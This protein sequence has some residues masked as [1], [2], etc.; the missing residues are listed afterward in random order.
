MHDTLLS[1]IDGS[2]YWWYFFYCVSNGALVT[3][4]VIVVGLPLLT[5][6]GVF[7]PKWGGAITAVFGALLAYLGLSGVS[8]SFIT[9]RNDL[10]IAKYRY[11]SDKD[12]TAKD[13]ETLIAAYEKAKTL[14]AYIPSAPST[15]DKGRSETS[16]VP[17]PEKSD[18]P[19]PQK[20]DAPTPQK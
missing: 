3:A 4:S 14:A 5:A 16:N 20:S 8:T 1:D 6:A 18:A 10:Q 12:P 11:Y 7:S 19:A 9:A 15:P 2:I 13:R 17:P